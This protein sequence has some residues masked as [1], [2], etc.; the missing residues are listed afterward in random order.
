MT[1]SL[2]LHLEIVP[3]LDIVASCAHRWRSLLIGN[4]AYIDDD[5]D[6]EPYST[7]PLPD[8]IIERIDHLQFPFLKRVEIL[9]I[10][11]AALD[12]IST[13]RAPSLEHLE[14]QEFIADAI[15]FPPTT[16]KSLK[17]DFYGAPTDN[18]LYPCLIPT[19]LTKL[20]LSGF[21]EAFSLPPSSI[22]L[23]LL[24]I[25]EINCVKSAGEF[26]NAIVA[27][28]LEQVEYGPSSNDPPS[29]ALNGLNTKFNNVRHLYFTQ[30]SQDSRFFEPKYT[31]LITLCKVFPGIRH[32]EL[33]GIEQLPYLFD[34]P[35]NQPN[36]HVR[37]PIDLWTELESLAFQGLHP[38]WLEP[39]QLS[40]WL[41]DRQALGLRRLHVK[42]YSSWTIIP[43]PAPST[44]LGCMRCSKRPV[45]WSWTDS[46]YL[47]RKCICICLW[48]LR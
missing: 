1:S 46:H 19:Q 34:P 16:L 13:T 47:Y 24:K 17:L 44:F 30:S 37:C 18:P 40:A 21:T 26:L 8:F 35:P 33:L 42:I 38:N 5:D 9:A 15:D 6:D 20:S 14:L 10:S 43:D 12:F 11:S 41:A 25:L 22:H 4:D 29:V 31:D 48:I 39:N 36:S 3:S 28:N 23:P 7:I 32:V 2:K 45:L 27:P